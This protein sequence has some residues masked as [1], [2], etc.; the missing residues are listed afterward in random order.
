MAFNKSEPNFND[1]NNLCILIKKLY[2]FDIKERNI[3]I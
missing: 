2:K 1:W 3:K